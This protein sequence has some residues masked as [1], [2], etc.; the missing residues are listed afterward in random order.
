VRAILSTMHS[1]TYEVIFCS[2]L[3]R[4]MYRLVDG[5]RWSTN[6][7]NMMKKIIWTEGNILLLIKCCSIGIC[8]EI[9]RTKF[10]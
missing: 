1:T 5:T 8:L 10:L 4:M 2:Y 7:L 6:P 3:K 9:S